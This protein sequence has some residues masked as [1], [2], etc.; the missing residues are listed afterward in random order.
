MSNNNQDKLNMSL[1]RAVTKAMQQ[2]HE[3]VTI[4]H[5]LYAIIDDESVSDL[6]TKIEVDTEGLASSIEKYL[7]TREDITSANSTIA[8]KKT[9]GVDRLFNRAIAQVMFA[10][11]NTVGC[12]DLIVSMLSEGERGSHAFYLLQTHGATRD[13]VI[14]VLQHEFEERIAK[15]G[16]PG[17]P[18]RGGQEPQIKFEDFVTNLNV[19]ASEGRID[20]V[21]GR[22]EELIDISEVLARRKKNNVII[23]GEPGVGKTA[24]AEGLALMISEGQVPESLENK[25]VY[26]LD[27]TSM[28]AG[29]KFR[30][31]FEERAKIISVSYTHLTLPTNREV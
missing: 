22:E 20:P 9:I 25:E 23:V 18:M 10:G 8:P 15:T 17:V 6:F 13:K 1:D 5:V 14:A 21:I 30:G 29:T 19:E 4:E 3:Y 11:G 12:R 7:Q 16:H 24:I 28:V 27:V 2:S 31:D 26:S